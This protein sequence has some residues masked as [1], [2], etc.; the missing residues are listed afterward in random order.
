[1]DGCIRNDFNI[2]PILKTEEFVTKAKQ[3]RGFYLWMCGW[4]PPAELKSNN[5]ANNGTLKKTEQ[6]FVYDAYAKYWRDALLAYHAK[7]IYPDWLS[8]QNEPDW[9]TDQ[10]E[11]C[12]FEPT[13][14]NQY[15]GY[16][17]AFAAV[18]K[19]FADID[20]KPFVGGEMLGW[21]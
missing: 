12:K 7:G 15:P 10:W 11:T 20:K 13:E 2:N 1:M 21:Q 18:M 19:Q 4:T 9:L 17:K 8:I 6:G 5:N 16:D 3:W 14:S